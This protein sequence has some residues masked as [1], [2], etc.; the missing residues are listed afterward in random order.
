MKVGTP[1]T[2]RLVAWRRD[3]EVSMEWVAGPDVESKARMVPG[4]E[5]IVWRPKQA[6]R[7]G[8]DSA[9]VSTTT[10]RRHEYLMRQSRGRFLIVGTHNEL[11]ESFL[12]KANVL[13]RLMPPV[14]D[15]KRLVE[16]LLKA[17]GDYCMSTVYAR[18]DEGGSALTSISLYG[19][20]LGEAPMFR[21]VLKVADP[22]RVQLRDVRKGID[23]LA[24]GQHGEVG[25]FYRGD[26]GLMDA[27]QALASLTRGGYLKWAER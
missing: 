13:W 5:S 24:I 20:D 8:P 18:V 6:V 27:Q 26:Q 23:V 3:L 7:V 9:S 11:V 10:V 21:E 12:R 25:F 4:W 14:V 15:I 17:P 19:A 16:D 22:F 1:L 2:G